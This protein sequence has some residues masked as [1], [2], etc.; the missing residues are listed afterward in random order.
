MKLFEID[1]YV[2]NDKVQIQII[3]GPLFLGVDLT[4]DQVKSLRRD[5]KAAVTKNKGLR[6]ST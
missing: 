1:P 2:D 4:Y 6:G 3:D 5:L